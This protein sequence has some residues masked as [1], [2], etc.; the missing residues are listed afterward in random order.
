MELHGYGTGPVTC[1]CGTTFTGTWDNPHAEA[2]QDC[3][4]CG[5]VTLAAWPGWAAHPAAAAAGSGSVQVT[6]EPSADR[7]ETVTERRSA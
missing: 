1:P 5:H 3:P 7:C 2:G 4:A 6:A